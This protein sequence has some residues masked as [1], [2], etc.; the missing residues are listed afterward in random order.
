MF[1]LPSDGSADVPADPRILDR[2]PEAIRQAC[3][4]REVAVAVFCPVID[5]FD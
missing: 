2:Q 3:P 4:R 1:G 5:T